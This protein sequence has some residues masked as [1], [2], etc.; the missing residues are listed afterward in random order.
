[1]GY[2]ANF[3][4]DREDEQFAEEKA[5]L[6]RLRADGRRR[7]RPGSIAQHSSTRDQRVSNESVIRC[8]TKSIRFVP[9]GF[10][11]SSSVDLDGCETAR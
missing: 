4:N 9:A 7:R 8:R 2:L 5:M 10:A 11:K 1:M 3:Q 6:T